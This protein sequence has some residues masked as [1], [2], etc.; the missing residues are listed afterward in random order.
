[1]MRSTYE[2]FVGTRYL[3]SGHRNRFISFISLISML[4]LALG[5][6]VLIVVLSVVNGFERELRERILG[7]TAHAELTG[8]QGR[9]D[10]W[11]HVRE[12]ALKNPQV[13]AGAP[14]IEEQGMLVNGAQ[15]SGAQVRGILPEEEAGVATIKQHMVS[16]RL[17]DLED[18]AYRIVLGATLAETLKVK[19]G[20]RVVLVVAQGSATPV[21]VMPRLKRF[22]VGSISPAG[23]YEYDRGLA[24]IAMPDAARLFRMGASMTGLR[25]SI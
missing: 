1:M 12:M 3:R 10:D 2:W 19:V 14:F 8:L 13:R 6:A 21:G 22:N 4:G 20:D 11:R 24:L 7:M 16:G 25:L 18:G 17:E 9:L 23:M 5:V 15:I